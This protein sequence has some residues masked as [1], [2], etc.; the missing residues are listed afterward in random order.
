MSE[1]RWIL[2]LPPFTN[3]PCCRVAL[4]T[5]L[6]KKKKY[7]IYCIYHN[8]QIKCEVYYTAGSINFECGS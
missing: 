3:G 1:Q 6:Y 7:Y 8:E 4:I 2:Y 5:N